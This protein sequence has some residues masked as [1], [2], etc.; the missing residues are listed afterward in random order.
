MR[1]APNTYGEFHKNY[2]D[3]VPQDNLYEALN[4]SASVS[5]EFWNS[6]PE[7]KGDYR[8][9]EGKWSIKELLQHIIDSERVFSYRALAFARGD[10]TEL[11]GYEENDYADNC[12]ADSR[13]LKDLVE[14]L[15]LVRKSTLSMFKS[16]D[17]SV[18]DS[19]GKA[20]GSNMSVRAAGFVIVGHEMHHINVVEERYLEH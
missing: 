6:I 1:P 7:E 11:P 20:S 15:E 17:D 3:L 8:Y 19:L 2:V 16:F 12:L 18:L 10:K 13:T 9:A 14:E 5:S 4:E